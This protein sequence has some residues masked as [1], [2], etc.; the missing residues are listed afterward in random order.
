MGIPVKFAK[1]YAKLRY[2]SAP[3]RCPSFI[4]TLPQLLLASKRFIDSRKAEAK[5]KKCR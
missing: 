3:R 5:R 4:L 2:G 1:V